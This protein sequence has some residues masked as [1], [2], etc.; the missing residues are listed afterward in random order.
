MAS[1]ILRLCLFSG[2]VLLGACS[3]R[4]GEPTFASVR[5]TP[6]AAGLSRVYFYRV[7]EPYESLA[8]P[9]IYLNGRPVAVSE[10]GGAFFRDVAPGAYEISVFSPGIY[11][12]QFKTVLLRP[13]DTLYVRIESLRNWYRGFNWEKDTFVVSLVGASEA[14]AEMASL[15]YT[16]QLDE[17]LQ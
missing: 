17:A 3:G 10:P 16:S 13:G 1:K 8:R 12:D 2:L 15:R 7:F 14:E 5:T 4:I 6:V 11:P 9:S